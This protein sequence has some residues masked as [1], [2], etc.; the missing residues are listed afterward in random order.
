MSDVQDIY[1]LSPLQQGLLFHSIAD[2]RGGMYVEQVAFRVEGT[3]N[4]DAF[5]RAWQRVIDRHQVLRTSFLWQ[6]LE[7]PVQVVH[8][9][10]RLDAVV[11]DWRD[12][13]PT[14]REARLTEF[15][16]TDHARGF[17]LARAPL[18]RVTLIRLATDAW[19]IV[20][21][22]HHLIFDGWSRATLLREVMAYYE[23]PGDG[24]DVVLPDPRPF[25]DY[26]AW[27]QA[28]DEQAAEQT[29]R[30]VLDGFSSPTPLPAEST[31][32]GQPGSASAFL[33]LPEDITAEL[34]RAARAHGLT[35]STVVQAVWGA[36]LALHSGSDDVVF[37]VT[38]AGRPPE[39]PG[40]EGMVGLFINTVPMRV[41]LSGDQPVSAWLQGVQQ[42]FAELRQHE[43]TPLAT[44]HGWTEV[45]RGVRLFDSLVV[46]ENYPVSD[47][48]VR[49][50]SETVVRDVHVAEQTEV[51][52]TLVAAPEKRL[53]LRLL[54]ATDRYGEPTANVLLGQLANLLAAIAANPAQPVGELS[55]ISPAQHQALLDTWNPAHTVLSDQTPLIARFLR[56]ARAHPDSIALVWNDTHYTYQWLLRRAAGTATR[57]Q[58][59]GVSREVLVGVLLERGPAQVIAILATN[60]AGGAYLPLDPAYPADRIDYLIADSGT[61][62]VLT[63]PDLAPRARV[64]TI[65]LDDTEAD[66]IEPE[67]DPAD[68]AYVIYTS[69]STGQPKGVLIPHG[70]ASRLFDATHEWFGFGPADVW[71]LFHSVSFDFSVWELWGALAHGGRLVLIDDLTRRSPAEFAIIVSEHAITVLNQTP[72]AFLPLTDALTEAPSL[73][74]VVFGGEA[75]PADRLTDWAQRFGLDRPALVNMYGITET[76]VHVTHHPLTPT[77]LDPTTGS[78]IGRPIPDLRIYLL[79]H[80]LRPVPAGVVGEVFVSGAG[81]ARGY[82]GRAGLTAHRFVP[83]PFGSGGERMYR[84]GDLARAL[85]DGTLVYV[86]RSDHQVQVRG[87]RIEP[88]EIETALR[89][90]PHVTTAHVQLRDEQL[91]AYLTTTGDIHDIRE[92]L[93]R[94]LPPHMHPAHY[95]VL[96]ALPLTTHGKI[97]TTALPAP[98]LDRDQLSTAYTP[99]RTPTEHTLVGI[100]QDVLGLDHIGTQD[101]FF[102]LGGDSIMSMR[103]AARATQ[104]GFR[105]NPRHLFEN[106]TI[107]ELAVVMESAQRPVAVAVAEPRGP[108][109]LT[110]IQ[111]W[112][113]AADRPAPQ[114]F[115]QA[116]VVRL[117]EPV[118]EVALR[119]ALHHLV[120]TH[121]SLRLRFERSGDGW[122]QFIGEPAD[123]ADLLRVADL[124]G[125]VDRSAAFE[126]LAAETQVSI[127]LV[128]GLLLRAVWVRL[129]D[130][131][132]RLLLVA[133]HLGV[134]GVS[135]RILLA[136]LAAAYARLVDGRSPDGVVVGTSFA[137]WAGR[138]AEYAVSAE[139]AAQIPLWRNLLAGA[140][141]RLP[142]DVDDAGPRTAEDTATVTCSLTER[143]TRELLRLGDRRV[144]PLDVLLA[145]LGLTLGE[146]SGRHRIVVDT[147]GHGREPLWDDV[148][149]AHTT[150]WFTSLYPLALVAGDPADALRQARSQVRSVRDGGIGYQLLRQRGVDFG[151]SDREVLF[152][153]LG[154][155]DE[156]VEDGPGWRMSDDPTGPAQDDRAARRYLI[157]VS[158]AI[159]DGTLQ[160]RWTYSP[161]VHREATV[162]DLASRFV[163]RVTELTAIARTASTAVPQ[164]F[165]LA[166][167]DQAAVERFASLPGGLDDLYPLS[168]MQQGMLFHLLYASSGGVNVEQVTCRLS[169]ALDL[170]ALRSAWTAV[171]ARHPVLRTSFHWRDGAEP[172][173]AVHRDVELPWRVLDWRDRAPDAQRA[174][175]ADFLRADRAERFVP[176]AAPLMR[177]TLIRT[178]QDTHELVWTH[179]HLLLDGWSLARVFQEVL[180][181]QRAA[182]A[183][184][185]YAP[186][187]VRPYREYL[188]WLAEQDQAEANTFWRENFAEVSA[189]TPLPIEPGEPVPGTGFAAEI[190]H[191]TAAETAAV[192]DCAKRHQLTVGTLVHAA[193]ALLLH[194]HSL[195]S[196]IVFGTVV[197]GRPAELP[198]AEAMVGQFINTQPVRLVV[199]PAAA[200]VDWLHDVQRHLVRAREFEFTPLVEIH[201]HSAVPRDK[202][203]FESVLVF[204]NYLVEQLPETA[205]ARVPGEPVVDRLQGREQTSYPLTLVAA[206]GEQVRLQLL[207]DGDR[208]AAQTARRL[209]EQVRTL[210]VAM[211]GDARRPIADLPVLAE[212]ER[213]Q[214]L[215]DWNDTVVPLPLDRAFPELFAE[216]VARTPSGV[217]VVDDDRR[218]TYAELGSDVARLANHLRSQGVGP[219]TRVALCLERSAELITSILAVWQAGGAYIPVDHTLSADR[220]A[221]MLADAGAA[222]VVTSSAIQAALP[223]AS[224]RIVCL[225]EDHEAIAARPAEPLPSSAGPDSL[226]YV[227]YTSG[228][229]GVPKGAMVEH[230]GMVNHL[231]AKVRDLGL[232]S[233]DTVAATAS[234]SFD[235]SVWQFF[236][237]MLTGG[238]VR[239]FGDAVTHDPVRLPEQTARASVT[240]LEI[241]PSM[242]RAI[243]TESAGPELPALRWLVLT[244]EA[245]PADL[246][247]GWLARYPDIPLLNAYGPTECSDDVTHHA[248]RSAPGQ[249]AAGVPIGRPVAN[250][251][252]Y[253][254]DVRQRPVPVGAPGELCVGGVG[255][256]RGYLGRPA[257]T[258]AAFM[259]D[260]YGPL[261][262]RLYRT[263]DLV[264]AEADGTLRFL[265][266]IDHQVKLRGFRIELG[267]IEAVLQRHPSAKDS[268]VALRE[269]TPGDQRLVA[270]VVLAPDAVEFDQRAALREHCARRLPEH[271]VPSAFV[272]LDALPLTPNGKLDRRALPPVG[273][274]DVDVVDAFDEPRP[275]MEQLVAAVWADVLGVPRIGRRSGFFALGGHSLLA[276]RVIARLSSA[277]HADLPLRALFDSPTLAE[278]AR[279]VEQDRTGEI[280]G[281]ELVPVS[282]DQDLPLSFAQQ[283]LWFLDRWAPGGSVYNLPMA[284]RLTGEL[285]VAALITGLRTVVRRHEALRTTFHAEDGT[286]H[287]V[288]A[289]DHELRVP[290]VDLSEL[291]PVAAL[292]RARQEARRDAD[293]AFDLAQGPLMRACVL[294]LSA[295]D[296]VLLLNL[297]HIVSDGWSSG[298]LVGELHELYT[299]AIERRPAQL[300]ALPVQYPDFAV[301]QRERLS[302]DRLAGELAHWRDALAG[303]PGLLALPTDRPRPAVQRHR[304][305]NFTVDLPAHVAAGVRELARR[306]D[307]TTFMVLFAGFATVLGRHS[308]QSDLLIGTPIANRTRPELE[309]LIGFFANTLVLR[310]DLTGDPTCQELLARVRESTIDAYAHQDL[311]FERLVEALRPERSPS[312]NPLVQVLFVLQNAPAGGA[313]WPG[314]HA[315]ALAEQP[316]GATARFDI[317]LS[318][319]ESA[320][321]LHANIEYNTDLFDEATIARL[322]R[323][324]ETVLTGAVEDPDRRVW[325]LAVLPEE[326]LR[327]QA[328][329]TGP[330]VE[331]PRTNLT[332]LLAR[333]ARRTPDAI[334][335]AFDDR[336]LSYRALWERAERLARRLRACGVGPDDRVGVCLDR[337]PE[338]VVALLGVLVAGAAY[339]PLD[340]DYPRERL[341]FMLADSGVPVLITDRESTSDITVVDPADV[342][343]PGGGPLPEVARDNLAYVIYT[344]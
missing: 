156:T 212:S 157:E 215:S 108:I 148:D 58:T 59:A 208:Y 192:L 80:R 47:D 262:S 307:A 98:H 290:V 301:W 69:G 172:L 177:L 103:I 236:S 312:H 76:T 93:A 19:E 173:Q 165:P 70:N 343:D 263:G 231:L 100:W 127:D 302:G 185:G 224:A 159:A 258:A 318:V 162:A 341:A 329:R 195:E 239:V 261:G 217:A 270:Y 65:T 45:P 250:T 9:E 137:E 116:I 255:V 27:L 228:S 264:R 266:R 139:L 306:S 191:L 3:F 73:R 278:F 99:P 225:D 169:G 87:H 197:A 221:F 202:A 187:P 49:G 21:S 226:A 330:A 260:P 182:L 309:A 131:G 149:L 284:V 246:C 299:A 203:L 180:A 220:I 18:L 102:T 33:E 16:R 140:D 331:Y 323:S 315:S 234:P 34:H 90:H 216:Q 211:T 324:Y 198:G 114:H 167:V 145:A 320:D 337:S 115:N 292:A 150:G 241:V 136:D 39:L 38:V 265:G 170:A 1:P 251:R 269:D 340:P 327:A 146:W 213:R 41:R 248:I 6:K 183:G 32:P 51:G 158:A 53:S 81:L 281:P 275:G 7:R 75:L 44:V 205:A 166:D 63:T 10:A 112:F 186:V 14:E 314:L 60:L 227:I 11:H 30:T 17:D 311:P 96:D 294:R 184:T 135:W 43:H 105:V 154:R 338:L 240:V 13:Q 319:R 305:A 237:A 88:G 272:L 253:V 119:A 178:G 201:G 155:F 113:F 117:D 219:E 335:V 188:G 55:L 297:H 2:E 175:L 84:T 244:G 101:N 66:V 276:M 280:G 85:P 229:T 193:W 242:L 322:V 287:Q 78:V 37:G 106:Q 218:L 5:L 245:L 68:L 141:G 271:L 125:A 23:Q 56:H 133:H 61:K 310:A 72:S 328:T 252:L 336:Q 222:V 298:L 288:V 104:A 285:D 89:T 128:G 74:T 94:Q 235:I 160:I 144:Q 223:P 12:L 48:S 171:V 71:S 304:G 283:R 120:G 46:F 111:H 174:A 256:G 289:P 57:L 326:E 142:V 190:L 308:G 35:L 233:T 339:V 273:A 209:T 79:D 168:P 40:V 95:V 200:T 130:E 286:P 282:R 277:V 132:E 181:F 124:S 232:T 300:P 54:Y 62:I 134:D 8:R 317:T 316:A 129:G 199:E 22:N 303:A 247:R 268:V 344:S 121:A 77:D 15:L 206:P 291:G 24:A 179:H 28:R 293:T 342:T 176:E 230:R 153:Y 67:I 296:H 238:T 254:L 138:L 210:L 147:E 91:V 118:D 332:E 42:T 267:E 82:L 123:H 321:G 313:R 29:W 334:A 333:Q 86:G 52:L 164:D 196:D 92:H 97:D 110:P 243:L 50:D 189:P 126:A 151:Q 257:R 4:A 109:P 163:A 152:N 64:G 194:R 25:R 214:V 279:A 204:E 259:P 249:D 31:A 122:Q 274:Q 207:Y 325:E 295:D 36:L 161:G 20:C 83:N 143:Q 107:A 26:V